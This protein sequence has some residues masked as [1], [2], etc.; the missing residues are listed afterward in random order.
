MTL[1]TAIQWFGSIGLFS[2]FALWV[3]YEIRKTKRSTALYLEQ[4]RAKQEQEIQR[5]KEQ[6]ERNKARQ[7]REGMI[8][9]FIDLFNRLID[10]QGG[11]RKEGASF[12]AYYDIVNGVQLKKSREREILINTVGRCIYLTL[13]FGWIARIVSVVNL[14]AIYS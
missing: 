8:N 9:P 12:G 7:Y 6:E 1:H 10:E 5:Q 2:V 11:Y 14:H 13:R 3:W 4:E